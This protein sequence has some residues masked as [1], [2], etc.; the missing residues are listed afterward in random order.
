[1]FIF[2]AVS[3][4]HKPLAL[5]PGRQLILILLYCLNKKG[6]ISWQKVPKA[7]FY[8]CR[9]HSLG[10]LCNLPYEALHMDERNMALQHP[11][12]EISD[13]TDRQTLYKHCYNRYTYIYIIYDTLI[14]Y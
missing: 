7:F 3:L 12:S 8:T 5:S 6:M 13:G 11:I 4:Q 1:M 2:V 14:S 10:S 9:I